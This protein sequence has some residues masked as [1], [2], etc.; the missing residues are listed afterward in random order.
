MHDKTV[1]TPG[2]HLTD[3]L[4]VRRSRKVN[5]AFA[6]APGP[7]PCPAQRFGALAKV[8]PA[9]AHTAS[10]ESASAARLGDKSPARRRDTGAQEA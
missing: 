3:K 1:T 6:V 8:L 4:K 10:G 7:I 2:G 9:R 5:G